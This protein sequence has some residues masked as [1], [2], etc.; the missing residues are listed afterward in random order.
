MKN[1]LALVGLVIV[2]FLGVGWYLDWY[3]AKTT[4]TPS[5]RHIEAEV[6]TPKI[7][8]DL[9]KAKEKVRDILTKETDKVQNLPSPPSFNVNVTPTG[10]TATTPGGSDTVTFPPI[11]FPS[12]PPG[13]T[14]KS[15]FPQ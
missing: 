15:P 8:Q 12:P 14:P 9:S 1:M 2:G 10:F 6:N 7:T 3:K 11:Q 4:L 5:G 13:S